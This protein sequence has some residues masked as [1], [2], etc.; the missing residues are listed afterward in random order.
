[1]IRQGEIIEVPFRLQDDKIKPHPALVVSN[2]IE[3]ELGDF[4]YVVLISTENIN[5]QYTIE[6]SPQML[7]KPLTEKS[8]FVTHLLDK[9]EE[10]RIMSKRN[11][12]VKPEYFE[13]V[14][15]KIM[16]NIFNLD[17]DFTE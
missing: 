12:Y 9:L 10:D 11:S 15:Q 6:I 5:P 16:K 13:V 1:M 17:L 14:L 2:L 8:Y 3:D 4:F 7:T